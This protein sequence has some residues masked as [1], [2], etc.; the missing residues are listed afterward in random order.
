MER[1]SSRPRGLVPPSSEHRDRPPG[2]SH[3]SPCRCPQQPPP[4]PPASCPAPSASGDGRDESPG[5]VRGSTVGGRGASPMTDRPGPQQLSCVGGP[6]HLTPKS[7]PGGLPTSHTGRGS[8]HTPS[9]RATASSQR[10]GPH[11]AGGR[12][13]H[14]PHSPVAPKRP[15]VCPC[16]SPP[17][18]PVPPGPPCHLPWPRGAR[19]GHSAG[20]T[21][22]LATR[23]NFWPGQE[24]R[25]RGKG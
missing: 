22:V 24:F 19:K 3:P 6:G 4:R 16:R 18:L 9:G 23:V 25:V 7:P 10:S 20:R 8:G 11:A 15:H 1:G 17:A 14:V 13:H 2:R 21:T 5:R 12:Q